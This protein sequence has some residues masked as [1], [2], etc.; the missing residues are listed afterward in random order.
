MSFGGGQEQIKRGGNNFNN[1]N[2]Y[3]NNSPQMRNSHSNNSKIESFFV[4][5]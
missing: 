1:G 3:N 2:G 5:S 4:N